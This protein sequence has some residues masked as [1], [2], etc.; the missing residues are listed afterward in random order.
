MIHPVPR[1]QSKN[2]IDSLTDA[3]KCTD[4]SALLQFLRAG[5]KPGATVEQPEKLEQYA[6]ILLSLLRSDGTET[7]M[8]DVLV[9]PVLTLHSL[10]AD[11]LAAFCGDGILL[12]GGECFPEGSKWHLQGLK[13]P[14]VRFLPEPG[15][16]VGVQ[17]DCMVKK[18]DIFALY[19]GADVRESEGLSVQ[20]FPPCRYNLTVERSPGRHLVGNMNLGWHVTHNVAGPLINAADAEVQFNVKVDRSYVWHD[21]ATGIGYAAMYA[22]DMIDKGQF[23]RWKYDPKAGGGGAE[24]YSFP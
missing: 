24:S 15:M 22:D 21:P 8:M 14:P 12:P 17:A 9:S 23:A 1:G 13:L 18:G 6:E 7:S 2:W 20:D 11:Q 16:G 5:M 10:D 3:K 4:S 19:A